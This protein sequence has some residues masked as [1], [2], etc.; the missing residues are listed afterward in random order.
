MS[1][2]CKPAEHSIL[3]MCNCSPDGHKFL[4]KFYCWRHLF[5][6]IAGMRKCGHPACVAT[7]HFHCGGRTDALGQWFCPE[8]LHSQYSSDVLIIWVLKQQ[9]F[10]PDIVRN[11]YHL[12]VGSLNSTKL[13]A[14]AKALHRRHQ[15]QQQAIATGPGDALP[16]TSPSSGGKSL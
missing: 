8:H 11:I 14:T 16:A 2:I 1:C 9:E 5:N 6:K 10:P 4:G 3:E 13:E 15:R 7:N 12:M